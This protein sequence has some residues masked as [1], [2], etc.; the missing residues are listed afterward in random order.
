MF[1]EESIINDELYF[2]ST[3][4]GRWQLMTAKQLTEKLLEARSDLAQANS[5]LAE[6]HERFF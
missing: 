6:L 4:D 1:Y 2:R 5:E 3:P